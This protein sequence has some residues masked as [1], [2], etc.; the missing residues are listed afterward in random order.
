VLLSC[1]LKWDWLQFGK[2]E[3]HDKD[4]K[5]FFKHSSVTCVL[6]PRYASGT[7]GYFKQKVNLIYNDN[8]VSSI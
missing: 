3:T 8:G 1:N 5:K 6:A 7:L 2:M 4:T